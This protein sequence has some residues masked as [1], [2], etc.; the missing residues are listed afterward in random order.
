MT[1]ECVLKD[2]WFWRQMDRVGLLS[3]NE[4]HCTRKTPI[5]R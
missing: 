1:F 4:G 2:L 3:I 5:T